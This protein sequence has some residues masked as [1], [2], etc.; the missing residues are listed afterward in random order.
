[1][2]YSLM[3]K[4]LGFTKTLTEPKHYFMDVI[5]TYDLEEKS[6]Q[7]SKHSEVKAGMKVLGYNDH[8]NYTDSAGKKTTYYLPNTTL[9]K[10]NS[11]P[12]NAKTDLLAVAKAKGA[13]VERLFADEFT[14]NWVAIPGKAYTS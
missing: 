11:T 2:A 4:N 7:A 14:D 13:T 5:I 10:K 1:M 6:T 12:T 3:L 9:W 8:F